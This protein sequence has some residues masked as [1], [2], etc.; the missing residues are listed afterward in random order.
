MGSV[1]WVLSQ[2]DNLNT[3]YVTYLGP[4]ED[5]VLGRINSVMFSFFCS[6]SHSFYRIQFSKLS[7]DVFL[8]TFTKDHRHGVGHEPE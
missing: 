5:L 8:P 7:I 1:I 6:K 2:D 3:S 4:G